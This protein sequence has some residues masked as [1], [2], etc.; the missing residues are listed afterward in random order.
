MIPQYKV[1]ESD[2]QRLIKRLGKDKALAVIVAI[3]YERLTQQQQ[4]EILDVARMTLYRWRKEPRFIKEYDRLHE[5][6]SW[7]IRQSVRKRKKHRY[8]ANDILSNQT[9]LQR[10]LS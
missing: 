4:A 7:F 9:L 2:Q 10:L 5:K 8:T 1:T 6:K 3:E